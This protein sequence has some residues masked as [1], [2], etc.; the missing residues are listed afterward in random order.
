MIP[1]TPQSP[2]RANAK[3]ADGH[4]HQRGLQNGAAQDLAPVDGQRGAG[5]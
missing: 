3:T 1:Q 2:N 4:T 5:H